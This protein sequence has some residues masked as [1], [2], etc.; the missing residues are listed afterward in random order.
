MKKQIP[1]IAAIINNKTV[2]IN[3]GLRNGVSKND[4]FDI[5]DSKSSILKDPTTGEV[6]GKFKQYKQRIYV[7]QVEDKYS[8]CTSIFEK[9]ELSD[10]TIE[11]MFNPLN[12]HPSIFKSDITNNYKKVT[13]G[14]KMKIS[15]EETKDI[16]AKYNYKTIHIGDHIIKSE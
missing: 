13:V 6:L 14:R 5:I 4:E 9:K 11:Q 2:I 3:Q 10:K 15:P 7:T 12:L 1:Q 16:L 8:I